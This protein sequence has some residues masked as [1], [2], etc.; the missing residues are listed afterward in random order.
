MSDPRARAVGFA[1]ALTVTLGGCPA[2]IGHT[3]TYMPPVRGSILSLDG[4]PAAF[5][6]VVA[7]AVSFGDKPCSRVLA[8]TRTDANGRFEMAAVQKTYRTTWIV[9]GLDVARPMYLVCVSVVDT[10]R[11]AFAGWG[12]LNGSFDTVDSL[13]CIEWEWR[14]ITRVNCDS[15]KENDVV[16]GGRW[17]DGD[18]SGYFRLIVAGDTGPMNYTGLIMRPRAYVQ[19]VA[20]S[21]GGRL[22]PV[23]S[24]ATMPGVTDALWIDEPRIEQLSDSGSCASVRIETKRRL[25]GVRHARVAVAL[26][27]P[28]ELRTVASCAAV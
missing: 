5:T 26:G 13:G 18:S 15:R 24:S 21:S 27:A 19:W 8:E 2:P 11:P 17:T 6:R 25:V 12:S 4:A 14:Y 28:G 3:T 20:G 7:A 23:I 10:L 9:P 22:Q 1:L 16:S